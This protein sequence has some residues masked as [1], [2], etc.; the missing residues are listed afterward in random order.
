MPKLYDVNIFMSLG[1]RSN[2]DTWSNT[3][4]IASDANLNSGAMRII[5]AHIVETVRLLHTTHV[6]FLR[7]RIKQR[8]DNLFNDP[9]Y[10]GF[11]TIELEGT[12]T[13]TPL[14]GLVQTKTAPL[15]V[16]L[17]VKRDAEYERAGRILLRGCIGEDEF[18]VAENGEFKLVDPSATGSAGWWGGDVFEGLD[19]PLP[20]G[21][22]FVIPDRVDTLTEQFAQSGRRVIS[23]RVGGI[24]I[25]KRARNRDSV[26]QDEKKLYQRKINNKWAEVYRQ[27]KSLPNYLEVAAAVAAIAAV[28]LAVE[29]IA[30]SAAA[31]GITGLTVP[32]AMW[33]AGKATNKMP[34]GTTLMPAL[35]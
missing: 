15:D 3:F 21:A 24:V 25:A 9:D 2:R 16:C 4:H 8:A 22:Y 23:H 19:Y 31:A 20:N 33:A 10:K 27:I 34:P 26:T 14:R 6:F 30:A 5:V 32:R 13:R 18:N 28:F 17:V 35:M 7:A 29:A 11:V 1:G 12:G